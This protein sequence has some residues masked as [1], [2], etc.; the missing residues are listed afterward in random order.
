MFNLDTT[1]PPSVGIKEPWLNGVSTKCGD[2]ALPA[3]WEGQSTVVG[4]RVGGGHGMHDDSTCTSPSPWDGHLRG[5]ATHCPQLLW[6]IES[7]NQRI[8]EL[9]NYSHRI[10][11]S[12]I[13]LRW[14]RP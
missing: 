11:E 9:Q 2:A 1:N 14:K 13:G 3:P 12:W 5:M 6:V 4:A 7:W 8:I 10:T